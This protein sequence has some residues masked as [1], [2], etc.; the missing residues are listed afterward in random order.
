MRFNTFVSLIF[1]PATLCVK[2]PLDALQSRQDGC[3]VYGDYPEYTGPCEDTGNIHDPEFTCD[4]TDSLG[5]DCGA[6]GT[7]CTETS[8]GCVIYPGELAVKLRFSVL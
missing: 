2:L 1:V 4:A 3:E 7:D 6:K 5:T 8:Q